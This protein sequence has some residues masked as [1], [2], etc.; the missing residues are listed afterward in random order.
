MKKI[1]L[2]GVAGF[3]GSNLLN[4]LLSGENF[5]VGIDNFDNFYSED[6]KRRNIQDNLNNIN[7]NFLKGDITD[8]KFLKSLDNDFD[9]IIH[10]AA[11]AGVRPSIDN[12]VGYQNTNVNGTLS[13]LEF[14][15]KTKVKKFVF[16]S[17]SSVYG[18]NQNLPWCE[19]ENLLPISPYASTK[20]SCENIGHVYSSLFDMQFIALRFFTVYGPGQRPD[21]A[22]HKFFKLILEN[23]AISVYGDGKTFRDYTYVDDICDGII[24]SLDYNELKFDIFNLGNNEKISLVDLIN[25]ISNITNKEV[26]INFLAEQQGDVPYTFADISKAKYHLNYSPKT[27]I[28]EG[29]LNFYS[30]IRNIYNLN[31][32]I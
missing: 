18:V 4:K 17:S 26:K 27:S 9:I 11:K 10:L 32:K 22:I 21:L 20:L 1:L 5:I 2:T 16:A 31:E 7:F 24:S 8:E 30:W 28:D 15:R 23:Q 3:I 29:L 6:I 19:D 12:P 25:K 14:A 13:L